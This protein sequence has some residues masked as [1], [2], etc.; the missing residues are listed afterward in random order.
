MFGKAEC[1]LCGEN[2]RFALRHLKTK[3]PE[4]YEKVTR[5]QMSKIMRKYFKD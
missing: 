5:L 2:V 3:H 4:E 1:R